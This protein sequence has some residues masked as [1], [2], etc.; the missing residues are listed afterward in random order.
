MN[1]FQSEIDFIQSNDNMACIVIPGELTF[2]CPQDVI[3]RNNIKDKLTIVL[4]NGD[5]V[6]LKENE[7][8]IK[9]DNYLNL[10]VLG[11]NDQ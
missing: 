10:T 4:S 11:I 8:L 2:M 6:K 5:N 7:L 1:K 3:K 9:I